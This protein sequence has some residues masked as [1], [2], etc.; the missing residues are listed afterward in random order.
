MPILYILEE[1][2]FVLIFVLVIW[3]VV[4]PLWFGLPLFPIFRRRKLMRELKEARRK[5]KEQRLRQQ[6]EALQQKAKVE[7]RRATIHNLDS[8]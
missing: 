4:V 7:R 3:R 8:Q 1:F 2:A 5:L 6:V